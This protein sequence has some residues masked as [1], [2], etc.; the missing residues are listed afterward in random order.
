MVFDEFGDLNV[1]WTYNFNLWCV[2]Q[3]AAYC[4]MMSIS[5]FS[6]SV[7]NISPPWVWSVWLW[8]VARS[9]LD[10]IA[11]FPWLMRGRA[12]L[13]FAEAVRSPWRSPW[14]LESLW[15]S[16]FFFTH[17]FSFSSSFLE[18]WRVPQLFWHLLFVGSSSYF[19]RPLFSVTNI[20]SSSLGHD[21]Q[22]SIAR[23]Y[24]PLPRIPV[25]SSHWKLNP[26]H[27]SSIKTLD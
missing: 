21:S 18:A 1:F 13:Y 19:L 9:Q 11:S 20:G 23:R 6:D 27:F 10:R 12:S 24:P 15:N 4:K 14:G 26:F 3:D 16:P 22:R 5:V 2:S 7:P 8:I 25:T 17:T